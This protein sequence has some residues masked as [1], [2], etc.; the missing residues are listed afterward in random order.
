MKD[1]KKTRLRVRGQWPP[2]E[3]KNKLRGPA[4]GSFSLLSTFFEKY[5]KMSKF[6]KISENVLKNTSSSTRLEKP[7]KNTNPIQT[8]LLKSKISVEIKKIKI[9]DKFYKMVKN[10]Q[11][12]PFLEK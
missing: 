7:A 8:S 6:M 12:Q 3:E 5:C 4:G 11:F 2:C 9:L 10:G 1:Q